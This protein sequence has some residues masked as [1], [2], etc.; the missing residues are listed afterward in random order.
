M[1]W[2]FESH[3]W[4]FDF[5]K[6]NDGYRIIIHIQFNCT[7]DYLLIAGCVFCVT[8]I[9]LLIV[10][11]EQIPWISCD[12]IYDM[13]TIKFTAATVLLVSVKTI[14][15]IWKWSE[16]PYW[17]TRCVSEETTKIANRK[18]RIPMS[19]E[20]RHTVSIITNI[21]TFG[22]CVRACGLASPFTFSISIYIWTIMRSHFERNII[23]FLRRPTHTHTYNWLC[24][25]G[26]LQRNRSTKRHKMA[27]KK[28]IPTDPKYQIV[29]LWKCKIRN[30]IVPG[31]SLELNQL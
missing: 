21:A 1:K 15:W 31:T 19:M 4:W 3:F 20:R 9:G 29:V 23:Q 11:W 18:S 2:F 10:N 12:Y 26:H 16:W 6:S 7:W 17:W 13:D 8:N 28:E 25:T 14:G 27:Q 30:S 24:R 22:V 5:H